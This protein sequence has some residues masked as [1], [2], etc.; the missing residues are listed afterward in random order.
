MLSVDKK[1]V[2]WWMFARNIDFC[3]K[4]NSLNAFVFLIQLYFLSH[5]GVNIQIVCDLLFSILII[6]LYAKYLVIVA[7]QL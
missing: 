1:M 2:N 3:V 7:S 4:Q 5:A 6:Q